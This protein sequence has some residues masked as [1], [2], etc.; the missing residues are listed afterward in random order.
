MWSL[1]FESSVIDLS[2][3]LLSMDKQVEEWGNPEH[4]AHILG[5]LVSEVGRE[6][7]P[8]P[9]LP[10]FTALEIFKSQMVP[11]S[12]DVGVSSWTKSE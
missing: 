9:E 3:G 12:Q 6:R 2:L 10:T 5:T 4:V 7:S 11:S 8:L 1:Q